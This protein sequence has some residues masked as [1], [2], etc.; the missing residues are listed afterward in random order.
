METKRCSKCGDV[1][2]LKEF[3]ARPSK[4][5]QHLA[6]CKPCVRLA[7]IEST[8][9]HIDRK[10]RNDRERYARDRD[11][12]ASQMRDRRR[13]RLQDP[14]ALEAERAR[15][16]AK[17]EAN[18][19]YYRENSKRH[20]AQHKD[21]YHA[22]SR[23]RRALEAAATI[24]PFTPADLRAD[25]EEH[26]LWGCIFCGGPVTSTTLHVEHFYPLSQRVEWR[27]PHAV[28]N[29]VPSCATCNLSKGDREPWAFLRTSLAARGID[30]DAC[31]ALFDVYE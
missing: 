21:V 25:W 16:R 5:G 4:P 27:G 7:N 17:S 28:W 10:R 8:A 11:H 20:Y 13:L 24:E 31:L 3:Y 12:L 29:L 14:V 18:R 2:R 15:G 22:R 6:R 1:K 23:A 9:R 26:D 19:D 30:L